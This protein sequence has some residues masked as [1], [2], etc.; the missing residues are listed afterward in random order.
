MAELNQVLI[1]NYFSMTERSFF[2]R[3]RMLVCEAD[4]R[5]HW[6]LGWSRY[7]WKISLLWKNGRVSSNLLQVTKKNFFFSFYSKVVSGGLCNR[8]WK[9]F[10]R[11]AGLYNTSEKLLLQARR[12]DFQ[13]G[14]Y[15]KGSRGQVTVE[16]QEG[17][18]GGDRDNLTAGVFPV[19][20]N[21]GT[22]WPSL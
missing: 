8:S 7:F 16:G 19:C 2:D 21:E 12:F 6:I 20:A 4:P 14:K 3:R 17:S 18:M 10:H 5:K 15:L 22:S 1:K 9:S 11:F 13:R